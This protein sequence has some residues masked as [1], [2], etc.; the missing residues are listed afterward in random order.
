MAC[1]PSSVLRLTASAFVLVGSLLSA[2][3]RAD[4]PL[5]NGVFRFLSQSL[6]VGS[7]NAEYLGQLIVVNADGPVSFSVS[8]LPPGMSLDPLTGILTGRPESTFNQDITFTADDGV[9]PIQLAV[10]LS[11]NA[12]GGGGNEGSTVTNLSLLQGRVGDAYIDTIG[13]TNGV[14][15]YLFGA[16]SLPPGLTLD[17][18]TGE[19]SGQPLAPG[20]YYTRLTIIDIGENNKVLTVLP[21][22]VL[23]LGSDFAFST[24]VLNNGEV[25]TSFCDT[26]TTTNSVGAVTHSVSGLPLGLGI[27]QG[28]G[29]VSGTPTTAGTY[30][31]V[32]SAT[33]S[34][35]TLTTNLTM[36]IA[37]SP[38]S[39]FYWSYFGIPAAIT[40]LSYDRQPPILVSAENGSSVS[41][42]AV[43]LPEGILYSPV[44]GELT[45]T[46][47]DIGEYTATFTATDS[48]TGETLQLS[49]DF[50]VLP[51]TGGDANS[52]AV[53]YWVKRQKLR[54]GQ[55]GKD[56]WTGS[57]IFNADRRTGS[58]F[59]PTTEALQ[60]ELGSRVMRVE[61]GE[62]VGNSAKLVAKSD[63]GSLPVEVVRMSPRRQTIR[64]STK[65]DDL[66]DSTP[67]T[68]RQVTTVGDRGYRLDVFFDAKGRFLPV[69]GLRR[70]AF[71]VEQALLRK[72][73]PG[74]DQVLLKCRLGDPSFQFDAI[75]DAL[76]VRLLVDGV[77]LLDKDFTALGL[78]KLGTDKASG[79]T[80]Y[81][82]KAAKD[83]SATDRLRRF[84]YDSR[85][86]VLLLRLMETDLSGLPG[87]ET[88]V[89]VE[90]TVGGKTYYTSVTLFETK[91]G[92][93][94]TLMP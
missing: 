25:G 5:D 85:S 67:G 46:S 77:V 42:S 34:Q 23:P 91:A 44:S 8:A 82:L 10:N 41:Y 16:V 27:D 51:P 87:L 37:T 94:S 32:L 70:A 64:W 22:Q 76:R 4:E 52:L 62:F 75:D 90:F 33:D 40:N 12:S 13:L 47:T 71:V 6:P 36:V 88:H 89:S 26:W 7:T 86:G 39:S 31:V 38:A 28:T 19:I 45:G 15:P 84:K 21:L 49:V 74:S 53:N 81:K 79:V 58:A 56:L 11:V 3:A 68:L 24:T 35:D 55:P 69:P 78:L 80:L 57:A 29:V 1:T 14:G 50:L 73:A 18:L 66:N 63:K 2:D 65:K 20:T 30:S 43:G 59:D 9:A 60:L 17:G 61:A 83:E 93:Y 72:Q 48:N 92:R 54:S